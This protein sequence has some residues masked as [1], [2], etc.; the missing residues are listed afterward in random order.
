MK[1][2]WQPTAAA[3]SLSSS[4]TRRHLSALFARRQQSRKLARNKRGLFK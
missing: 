3:I 1:E 2:K 4:G